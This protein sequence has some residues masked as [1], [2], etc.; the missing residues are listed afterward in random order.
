VTAPAKPGYLR[1]FRDTN[2]RI[3]SKPRIHGRIHVL[4]NGGVRVAPVAVV[5][6]EAH[7]GMYISSEMLDDEDTLFVKEIG[8][9][10]ARHTGGL[11]CMRW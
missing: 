4:R 6:A 7:I 9:G 8:V 3:L 5:T 2:I 1:S 10:M 11:L